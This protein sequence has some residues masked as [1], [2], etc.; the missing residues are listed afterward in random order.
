MEVEELL[1]SLI[2]I[3]T[4]NPPGREKELAL[5]LKRVFDAA[6][7]ANELMAREP[8]RENFI[9][10]VGSGKKTL[11]FLA[12][13]DVVP[14]GEGWNVPPFSGEIRDGTVFGRG[15]LDCKALVAAEAHAMLQLAKRPGLNGRLVF[16]ATADEEVGGAAGVK[17]LLEKHPEQIRADFCVNEGGN[18]PYRIRDRTVNFVQVGE[19][20]VAWSKLIARGVSCHGSTPD[21]GKNAI[22]LMGRAID[23]LSNY[24]PEINLL[25]DVRQL[26]QD[27]VDLKGADLTVTPDTVDRAI[28]L[29]DDRA[30]AAY[31]KAITRMTVSANVIRGGSKTNIVPDYCETE[32]D[33][34]VLPGQDEG[35]I[36]RE[37]NRTLGNEVEIQVSYNPPSFSPT[38]SPFYKL[39]AG[40]I[41][42]VGGGA[43]CLPCLSSGGTDSRHLRAAGIPCYGVEL[44]A[45]GFDEELRRLPHA[46]NERIDVAS[47]RLKA[48][49]LVRLAEKYLAD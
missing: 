49:F 48:D 30:F 19:K 46:R 45:P 32:L 29:F 22:A 33:I 1:S 9:A 28:G 3:N 8:G 40:T 11:L 27:M 6:G 23:R 36:R 34:R 43:A 14:A 26:I 12:H 37:L 24:K 39:V 47:L 20:G 7:I 4:E 5:F 10:T 17:F 44:M 42:E 16:A 25:P 13:T 38:S 41:G 35:Y 21:L 2:K 31:L 15:A 18:A